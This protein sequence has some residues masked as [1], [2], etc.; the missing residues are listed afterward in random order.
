MA[1]LDMR[2]SVTKLSK[3]LES[4]GGAMPTAVSS[5]NMTS[6]QQTALESSLDESSANARYFNT[7]TKVAYIWDGA[8]MQLDTALVAGSLP[9]YGL[10]RNIVVLGASAT[11]NTGDIYGFICSAPGSSTWTIDPVDGASV[12]SIPQAAFTAGQIYAI[13]ATSITTPAGGGALLF[14]G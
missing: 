6:A 5:T 11:Y 9:V 13:H 10:A 4:I 2:D 12:G 1:D 7:E 8:A 14:I 3:P